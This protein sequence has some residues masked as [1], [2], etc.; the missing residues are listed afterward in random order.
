MSTK[1]ET[2]KATPTIKTVTSYYINIWIAGDAAQAE[3]V[4]REF[5]KDFALCVTVTPTTYIY[6]GGQE[7]G[8]LV[9]LMNY[10]R[11]PASALSLTADSR[12]LAERLLKRLCQHSFLL[13]S[14]SSSA[15]YSWRE[16]EA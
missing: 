4:C 10:P 6:S 14:P 11:F 16:A 9:R 13:E 5:C 3:Q 12:E 2:R 15:W 7:C 8:V 1:H